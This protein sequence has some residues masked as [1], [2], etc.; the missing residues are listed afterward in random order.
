METLLELM[1]K[2]GFREMLEKNLELNGITI[3][4]EV[5]DRLERGIARIW[6]DFYTP[7]EVAQLNALYDEPVMQKFTAHGPELLERFFELGQHI[8]E[9]EGL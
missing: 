7:E 5:T 6:A 8:A 9:E 4:Q 1:N 3:T 2:I